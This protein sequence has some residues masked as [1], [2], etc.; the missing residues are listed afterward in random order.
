M[1]LVVNMHARVIS[2]AGVCGDRLATVVFRRDTTPM[3]MI[4]PISQTA[5]LGGGIDQREAFKT[6]CN[7][8]P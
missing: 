1:I 2:W 7:P 6:P 4:E 8:S 3:S 5:L